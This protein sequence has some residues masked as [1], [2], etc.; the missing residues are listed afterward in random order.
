MGWHFTDSNLKSCHLL[1]KQVCSSDL[2]E[3]KVSRA[4]FSRSGDAFD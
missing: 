1:L 2:I 3:P 4:A